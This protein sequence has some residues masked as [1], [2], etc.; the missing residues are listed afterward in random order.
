M[1]TA[2]LRTASPVLGLCGILLASYL[3]YVR[4]TGATLAC[5]SGG[6]ERVQSSQH[7]EVLGVPVVLLGLFAYIGILVTGVIRRP[8]ASLA[9]SVLALAALGYA[10]Y[11]LYVQLLVVGTVCDWCLANDLLV[12]TLAIVSAAR[13]ATD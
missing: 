12:A 1:T 5:V 7:A 8:L 11:L 4:E 13:W 3:L 2:R 10:A 6:C 9:Q